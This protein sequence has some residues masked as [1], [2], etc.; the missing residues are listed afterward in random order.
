MHFSN[1]NILG[2]FQDDSDDSD[3]DDSDEAL[4]D[5][6]FCEDP[7][8]VLRTRRHRTW[9]SRHGGGG[10]GGDYEYVPGSKLPLFP[11]NRGWSST[12]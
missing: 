2:H 4:W 1:V 6:F 11:Y 10:G 5:D 3:S 12:H 8:K 9:R 7:S